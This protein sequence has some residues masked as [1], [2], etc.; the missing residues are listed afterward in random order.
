[1]SIYDQ[2]SADALKTFVPAHDS[3]VGIDSDGCVFDTMEIKQKQCFHGLIVKAWDLRAIEP[4]VRQT[5]E[6]VNLY[7]RSRGQ[8]RF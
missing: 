6:F 5:A 1:M 2:Y 3:F 7:S 8:N 4:E